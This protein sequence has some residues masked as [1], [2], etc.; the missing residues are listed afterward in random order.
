MLPILPRSRPFLCGGRGGLILINGDA[1]WGE[2]LLGE[3]QAEGPLIEG[4]TRHVFFRPQHHLR[5][6]YVPKGLL[7][8]TGTHQGFRDFSHKEEQ[9]I[10]LKERGS[11]KGYD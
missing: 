9:K 2:V 10:L 4:Q 11:L 8:V 6:G 1:V 5:G 7:W 3:G